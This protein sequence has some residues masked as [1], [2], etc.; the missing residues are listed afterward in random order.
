[1]F[2]EDFSNNPVVWYTARNIFSNEFEDGLAWKKYL[3]W[4][5]LHQVEELVS[6]DG[7]LNDLAFEPDFNEEIDQCV[8]IENKIGEFFKTLEYV[9][10]KSTEKLVYNL[11]AV[12][13][14]PNKSNKNRLVLEFDFIGYD[15]IER[16][17]D[18]SALVNCGGFNET[19]QAK[20]LNKYG[21]ISNY[22]RAKDIQ[23]RLPENNPDEDHADCNLFEVWRHKTIGRK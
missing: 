4:S 21:L 2:E 16:G 9:K 7:L 6:L 19:F 11:L 23:Q 22:K 3:D 13:M 20:E 18:I 14:E 17:A 15:L 1:M 5:G 8:I 10:S 12:I